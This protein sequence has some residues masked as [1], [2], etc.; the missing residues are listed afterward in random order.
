MD[1]ESVFL[2]Y[3]ELETWNDLEGAQTCETVDETLQNN[4]CKES[5]LYHCNS[6][7]VILL[8]MEQFAKDWKVTS[9]LSLLMEPS[10]ER[11]HQ[12]LEKK[13]ELTL[14][15]KVIVRRTICSLISLKM[16]GTTCLQTS[17]KDHHL[18]LS[19]RF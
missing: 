7:S 11:T 6:F 8:A 16:P 5:F 3:T 1:W 12:R 9:L 2:L 15:N 17:G 10:R 18:Q 14:C 19:I 4:N 13:T